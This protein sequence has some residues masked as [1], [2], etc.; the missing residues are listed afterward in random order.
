M[1]QKNYGGAVMVIGGVDLK[2]IKSMFRACTAG[3]HGGAVYVRGAGTTASIH[4][5]LFAGNTATARDGGAL[6]MALAAWW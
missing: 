4:A 2:V 6:S 5:S 3:F 1:A